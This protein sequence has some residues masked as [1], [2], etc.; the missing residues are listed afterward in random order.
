MT[1]DDLVEIE[2]IKRLKYR[3]M[4]CLDQKLWDELATCFVEEAT[5]AYSGGHYAVEGRDA[6]LDW[7]RATMGSRRAFS[8]PIGCTTPRSTSL[9][10]TP[11]PARGRS[12]TSW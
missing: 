10:P 1:A 3:Y 11:P 9:V 12:R 8:P 7:L 6:I 4:R 5:V 2:L